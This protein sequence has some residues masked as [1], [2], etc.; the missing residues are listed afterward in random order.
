MTKKLGKNEVMI[1]SKRSGG[2]CRVFKKTRAGGHLPKEDNS[3]HMLVTEKD[4]P[5]FLT[6]FTHKTK[7]LQPEPINN[8]Y[9]YI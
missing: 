7:N 6:K 3:P 1:Q 2:G 4:L 5:L 9:I 8:T